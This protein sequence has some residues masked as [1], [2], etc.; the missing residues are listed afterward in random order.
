VEAVQDA[1]AAALTPKV[2]LLSV[3]ETISR[4]FRDLENTSLNQS[5]MSLPV[6]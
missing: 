2:S 4:K 3:K 5:K 1:V 6:K